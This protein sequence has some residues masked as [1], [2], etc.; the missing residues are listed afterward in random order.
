MITGKSTVLVGHKFAAAK[1]IVKKAVFCIDN[2]STSVTE[3]DLKQFVVGLSVDVKSCF[4]V[5][6]RRFHYEKEPVK[7]RAAFRLCI[8]DKD[9]NLLLDDSK[10]PESIVIS[11]WFHIDP[12]NRRQRSTAQEVPTTAAA[13]AAV[14]GEH[15]VSD[16]LSGAQDVSNTVDPDDTMVYCS[17]GNAEATGCMDLH[18]TGDDGE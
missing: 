2:L 1:P 10:W 5:K 13:A 8:A 9:R 3:H 14:S 6:P 4:R 18:I 7:D 17:G 11:E 16:G 12:A 15:D